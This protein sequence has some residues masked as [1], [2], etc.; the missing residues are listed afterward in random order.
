MERNLSIKTSSIRLFDLFVIAISV[1][2]VMEVPVLWAFHVP[3]TGI[4]FIF[5]II[6]AAVF[7]LDVVRHFLFPSDLSPRW[8]SEKNR[9][10]TYLKGWFWVD[11]LAALPFTILLSFLFPDSHFVSSL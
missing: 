8:L 11:F 4:V 7:S 5:E 6:V 10:R 3:V 1:I 2:S 9:V